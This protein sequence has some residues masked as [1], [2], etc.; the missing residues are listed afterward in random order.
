MDVQPSAAGGRLVFASL[1]TRL[2]LWSLPLDA[3]RAVSN[4]SAQRLTDDALAHTYPAVSPDGSKVAFSLQRS[5]NRD[6]WIKNLKTGN[7]KQVSLPPGSS[8]NPNFSPD[9]ETLAYRMAENGSSVGYAVSLAAGGTETICEDCSDYGWSSD[10]KRL[11]LV[12]KT[13]ARVSILDVATKRKTPLLEHAKYL[14]WNPRF[15]PDDRWVSF[16]ATEPG[17]SRVFVAPVR[18]QG[19]IPE[20]EWITI[21]DTG[22]DDKPRWS[23]DGNT[24]YLISER[25]GFRC[26]WAQRQ[27]PETERPVG[28]SLEVYHSHSAR[29]SLLNA[30]IS[31]PW[32]CTSLPDGSCFTSARSPATSGWRPA[33][34]HHAAVPAKWTFQPFANPRTGTNLRS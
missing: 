4:G 2:D 34:A 28:P 3:D 7:E 19:T 17:Q 11:V 12:A 22:W 30:S 25:D 5:G 16:N 6:V 13:P 14:L 33:E 9:G 20:Q 31:F 29:R 1:S 24:L 15:S 10:K 18:D 32:R 26:I 21:A 23:P 27:D 8:F